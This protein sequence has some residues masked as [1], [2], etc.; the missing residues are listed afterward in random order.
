MAPRTLIH[1]AP[2]VIGPAP[3]VTG[4]AN[5]VTGLASGVIGLASGVIGLASGVIGLARDVIDCF[6]DMIDCFRELIASDTPPPRA[7]PSLPGLP[8][9]SWPHPFSGQEP[10]SHAPFDRASPR[11]HRPR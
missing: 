8:L 4:L 1:F 2:R 11:R 5:D 9:L 7:A 3:R 6:P 10:S